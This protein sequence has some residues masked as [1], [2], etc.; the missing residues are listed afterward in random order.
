MNFLLDA[1]WKKI[2]KEAVKAFA[3][4]GGTVLATKI[5]EHMYDKHF[6]LEDCEECE[7]VEQKKPVPKVV[8]KKK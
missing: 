3:I 6:S 1:A 4:A 8:K 5:I 7:E 2:I